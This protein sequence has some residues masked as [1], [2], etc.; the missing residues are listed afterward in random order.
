MAF[1]RNFGTQDASIKQALLN[2][3]ELKIVHLVK[4][5]RPSTSVGREDS[6]S[7][8]YFTDS[9]NPE[10]FDDLSRDYQRNSNG[11]QLYLQNKLLKISDIQEKELLQNTSLSLSFDATALGTSLEDS[12]A[13]TNTQITSAYDWVESGFQEGDLVKFTSSSSNAV[14]TDVTIR[15]DSFK[16]GIA[17]PNSV[18]TFTPVQENGISPDIGKSYLAELASDEIVTFAGGNAVTSFTQYLNRTVSIYR[19]IYTP[20]DDGSF[21]EA[22]TYL[23]FKGLIA[24]GKLKEDPFKKSVMTWQISSHWAAFQVVNGRVTSDDTHR[25]LKS[26]QI[27]SDTSSLKRDEYAE[28]YGFMHADKAFNVAAKYRTGIEKQEVKS[29]GKWYKKSKT[30]TRKWIEWTAREQR[31]SFNLNSKSIPIVYGVQLIEDPINVFADVLNLPTGTGAASVNHT[32]FIS[33]QA[34]CE[35]PISSILD[36]VSNDDSSICRDF[37]DFNARSLSA[38]TLGAQTCVGR[39]DRGDVL[40]GSPFYNRATVSCKTN[41]AVSA[42]RRFTVDN[43]VGTL[44]EGMALHVSNQLGFI[45]ISV[46]HSQTD[47]ELSGPVTLADNT[48]LAFRADVGGYIV[49]NSGQTSSV[50]DLD[51]SAI[52]NTVNTSNVRMMGI[53]NTRKVL[54]RWMGHQAVSGTGTTDSNRFITASSHGFSTGMPLTYINSSAGDDIAGLISGNSYFLRRYNTTEFYLHNTFADAMEAANTISLT[55]AASTGTGFHIFQVTEVPITHEH[56]VRINTANETIFF[57]AGLPDQEAN[58]LLTSIANAGEIAGAAKPVKITGTGMSQLVNGVGYRINSAESSISELQGVT[59]RVLDIVSDSV[60]YVEDNVALL[61]KITFHRYTGSNRGFASLFATRRVKTFSTLPAKPFPEVSGISSNN[62]IEIHVQPTIFTNS[63]RILDTMVAPPRLGDRALGNLIS[64]ANRKVYNSGPIV[65]TDVAAGTADKGFKIQHDYYATSSTPY[66]SKQHRLLDTAYIVSFKRM[67]DGDTNQSLNKYV[68]KGKFVECYNYDN[69]FNVISGEASI[70]NYRIGD[71]VFVGG[72][73]SQL[74]LN[75][76][77]ASDFDSTAEIEV[78]AAR[79]S[80]EERIDAAGDSYSNGSVIYVYDT[81]ANA[82]SASSTIVVGH[83]RVEDVYTD[84]THVYVVHET[85]LSVYS[86]ST[87]LLVQRQVMFAYETEKSGSAVVGTT[88]SPGSARYSMMVA[89]Q[90]RLVTNISGDG[91]Y[92]YAYSPKHIASN[93]LDNIGD[94][95]STFYREYQQQYQGVY[96]GS[97]SSD[98]TNPGLRYGTMVAP[99]IY[100]FRISE[101][102]AGAK[103]VKDPVNFDNTTDGYNDTHKD[104]FE[105]QSNDRRHITTTYRAALNDTD[106]DNNDQTKNPWEGK[107]SIVFPEQFIHQA[108]NALIPDKIQAMTSFDNALHC[109]FDTVH[110]FVQDNEL[111][112]GCTTDGTTVWVAD[113]FTSIGKPQLPDDGNDV[114]LPGYEGDTI[115]T[116]SN[117]NELRVFINDNSTL[118]GVS[119]YGGLQSTTLV[120]SFSG[121]GMLYAYTLSNGA[122]DPAKDIKPYLPTLSASLPVVEKTVSAYNNRR[123]FVGADFF[124]PDNKF[125][126]GGSVVTLNNV[127][128]IRRG[129]TLVFKAADT[130]SYFTGDHMWNKARAANQIYHPTITGITKQSET[131]IT[132]SGGHTFVNGDRIVI[133]GGQVTAL[134]ATNN[135]RLYDTPFTVSDVTSTTF[136]LK[137]DAGTYI[138]SS[139]YSGTYSSGGA[140]WIAKPRYATNSF[141]GGSHGAT[142]LRSDASTNEVLLDRFVIIPDIASGVTV[143]IGYDFKNHTRYNHQYNDIDELYLNTSEADADFHN[144]GSRHG[145]EQARQGQYSNGGIRANREFASTPDS[146]YDISYHDIGGVNYMCILN[147]HREHI[148]Q[149][150]TLTN[151]G[152]LGAH[153]IHTELDDPTTNDNSSYRN[154]ISERSIGSHVYFYNMDTGRMFTKAI[155]VPTGTV[156]ICT[157]TYDTDNNLDGNIGGAYSDNNPTFLYCLVEHQESGVVAYKMQTYLLDFDNTYNGNALSFG[158]DEIDLNGNC[159]TT[160]YP[161]PTGSYDLESGDT[162]VGWRRATTGN[163]EF[164]NRDY[165]MPTY[166]RTVYADNSVEFGYSYNNLNLG[167]HAE[168]SVNIAAGTGSLSTANNSTALHGLSIVPGETYTNSAGKTM[169][170]LAT[171][172][173]DSNGVAVILTNSTTAS[174]KYFARTGVNGGTDRSN[175]AGLAI[176]AA[177]GSNRYLVIENANYYHTQKPVT[178]QDPFITAYTQGSNALAVYTSFGSSGTIQLGEVRSATTKTGVMTQLTAPNDAA[179][180]NANAPFIRTFDFAPVLDSDTSLP[181]FYTGLFQLDAD[182]VIFSRDNLFHE[183]DEA[184]TSLTRSGA[185]E[186]LHTS[187]TP[188]S[189]VKIENIVRE[190]SYDGTSKY[191]ISFDQGFPTGEVESYTVTTNGSA[192]PMLLDS[193]LITPPANSTQLVQQVQTAF[194]TQAAGW[195]EKGEDLALSSHATTSAI[196]LNFNSELTSYISSSDSNRNKFFFG[197]RREGLFRP[198]VMPASALGDDFRRQTARVELEQIRLLKTFSDIPLGFSTA[199]LSGVATSATVVPQVEVIDSIEDITA[200]MWNDSKFSFMYRHTEVSDVVQAL[201]NGAIT[202]KGVDEYIAIDTATNAGGASRNYPQI[203]DRVYY[204]GM[205]PEEIIYVWDVQTTSSSTTNNVKLTSDITSLN[206]NPIEFHSE[207]MVILGCKSHSTYTTPSGTGQAK[208]LSGSSVGIYFPNVVKFDKQ[209]H[210]TKANT[211]SVVGVSFRNEYDPGYS[212]PEKGLYNLGSVERFLHTTTLLA[213]DAFSG[214]GIVE[215]MGKGMHTNHTQFKFF[216]DSSKDLRVSNNPAL[217]LLDYITSPIYGKGLKLNFDYNATTGTRTISRENNDIDFE[218]FLESARLCD[219][220]S[221]VTLVSR[222]D[223]VAELAAAVNNSTT[224]TLYNNEGIIKVGDILIHPSVSVEVTVTNVDRTGAARQRDITVSSAVS[225]ADASA[226]IFRTRPPIVGDTY[227]YYFGGNT[228]SASITAGNRNLFSG[229]VENVVNRELTLSNGRVARYYEIVFDKV[230]GYLGKKHNTWASFNE[231]IMYLNTQLRYVGATG[232]ASTPKSIGD[233]EASLL[234]PGDAIRLFKSAEGAGAGTRPADPVVL[235]IGKKSVHTNFA[236]SATRASASTFAMGALDS[237]TLEVGMT[238]TLTDS[239]GVSRVVTIASIDFAANT[240][241]LTFPGGANLVVENTAAEDTGNTHYFVNFTTSSTNPSLVSVD[242]NPVV[243][244]FSSVNSDFSNSGYSLYDSDHVKYWRYVGW[245]EQD[246]KY[247]TRHQTNAL[248]DTGNSIFENTFDLLSQFNGILTFSG[249]LYSLDVKR[250]QDVDSTGST[251]KPALSNATD[252]DVSKIS[253][254]DIIGKIT[255]DDKGVKSSFNSIEANVSDPSMLFEG[256]QVSFFNSV[257]L[258]E[259]NN[260]P[261]KGSYAA[262]FITNYFN[263]RMNVKQYLDQSRLSLNISFTMAPRGALLKAGSLIKITYDRFNFVEKVFRIS[264]ITLKMNGLVDIVAAEHDDETYLLQKRNATDTT[265]TGGKCLAGTEVTVPLPLLYNPDNV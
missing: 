178:R 20:S 81:D 41:G 228:I 144:Q 58:L 218:S 203:G 253:E 204:D 8:G 159:M 102:T 251:D 16:D 195:D 185:G 61:N 95:V 131:L 206:N 176:V 52:G 115:T 109:Y 69:S 9:S 167:K 183:Y 146:P 153:N 233:V 39:A 128:G 217:Q 75:G 171:T 86:I 101:L 57:H 127:T 189:G 224:V 192:N 111:P 23:L 106:N 229:V 207:H 119:N 201:I 116:L 220:K 238:T 143:D 219:A 174:K 250:R 77:V 240:V 149:D 72:G 121:N 64:S 221:Q 151:S 155:S 197:K 11:S 50:Q 158:R 150:I 73:T 129:Q 244:A 99:G 148:A 56:G 65:I 30:H 68:I 3:P 173:R 255:I 179:A 90:K 147:K 32:K 226:I 139:G 239:G 191:R 210:P 177:G 136:K 247:A 76:I 63:A 196:G 212:E 107:F 55:N 1:Y 6:V 15:I 33:V 60:G 138:D 259:D 40:V 92:I 114:Y 110:S 49:S 82:L 263:A 161:F 157:Y 48:D 232:A 44:A 85:F 180:T 258:E 162:D 137:N 248:I 237:D 264:D 140:A 28:D 188:L 118:A 97:N 42:V 47:I 93:E 19:R 141:L 186:D 45:T 230:I 211:D 205:R 126:S 236:E 187:D 135:E 216:D 29:K 13:F 132:I 46:V 257:Y 245:N 59:F 260:M 152:E 83:A 213:Y 130:K 208:L 181:I 94:I 134:S 182:S 5:E 252:S 193:K 234:V 154:A 113:W 96:N 261:K 24:N 202:E 223:T 235:D 175:M 227:E 243:K 194:L 104:Q 18:I 84:G 14:N 168:F 12:F 103:Y 163:R 190:D 123:R 105:R 35:G 125:T 231:E 10:T 242:G 91:T 198:N 256:R 166:A 170:I 36:I 88:T 79:F 225:L 120:K 108:Q 117:I 160:G 246:Q 100:K 62:A 122:R 22:G 112:K 31:L 249:G 133:E 67:L 80:G 27:T 70:A 199:A 54:E 98:I 53:R 164:R 87:K 43:V 51:Y 89:Q 142:V 156:G 222:A 26:N 21:V 214:F 74:T 209:H 124:A 34:L 241:V 165:N 78:H 145:F 169:P 71:S 17:T 2:S 262:P 172:A 265:A 38:A 215:N 66:W 7:Y 25:A 200:Q 184:A 254:E 37:P 4:F